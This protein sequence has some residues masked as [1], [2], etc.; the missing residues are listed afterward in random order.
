M[1]KCGDDIIEGLRE[2]L[3]H[4]GGED[5]SGAVVHNVDVSQKP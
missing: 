1:T 3:A 4:A 5:I 2:A